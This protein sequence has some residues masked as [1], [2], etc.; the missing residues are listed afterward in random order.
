MSCYS[1]K[2]CGYET[3]KTTNLLSHLQAKKICPAKLADCDRDELIEDLQRHKR[4]KNIHCETCKQVFY[5]KA[6]LEKH[7]CSASPIIA[8][9]PCVS[10]LQDTVLQLN[11]RIA[12]LEKIIENAFSIKKVAES[13]EAKPEQENTK[14]KPKHSKSSHAKKEPAETSDVIRVEHQS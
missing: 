3:N 4:K 13:S 8:E 7:T 12:V 5:H 11:K 9:D 14:A 10:E 6:Q 1:C 2:R